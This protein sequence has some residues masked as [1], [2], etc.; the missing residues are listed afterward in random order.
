MTQFRQNKVK[1][2]EGFWRTL[3]TLGV[4]RVRLA[5]HIGLP[6]AVL[7]NQIAPTTD[8][9]FAIWQA[10]PELSGNP[11]IGFEFAKVIQLSQLPPELFVASLAKDYRGALNRLA[12]Y[13]SLCAPETVSIREADRQCTVEIEWL[14]STTPIPDAL[15][16]TTFSILLGL[17]SAQTGEAITASH[18]QLTRTSATPD[19]LQETYGAHITFGCPKNALTFDSSVLD[20][21]LTTYNQGLADMLLPQLDAQLNA[22]AT[23]APYTQQVQWVIE[24]YLSAGNPSIGL[25]AKELG[26]SVRSLQRKIHSEG[27]TYKALLNQVRLD[28]A[29]RY[30]SETEM[31]LNEIAALIGYEDHNSFFRAFKILAGM[32]PTVWR[33]R[34]RPPTDTYH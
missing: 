22:S 16:D 17:G 26:I 2:N 23:Q 11:Q 3:E 15:V 32:P 18:I 34:H 33:D 19:T 25:V 7:L 12:R 24:H 28:Q 6:R 30:L 21:E 20:L 8:Q 14:H 10:L 4:C 29:K 5:Q 13:K 27:Q 31:G 1:I 9:F